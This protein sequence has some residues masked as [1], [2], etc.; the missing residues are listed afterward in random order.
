[1]FLEDR[2]KVT[3]T[4]NLDKLQKIANA[5]Q[6][7]GMIID[8]EP[9]KKVEA[10]ILQLKEQNAQLPVILTYVF[11]PALKDFESSLKKNISAIFY[12]PYDLN[13]VADK[14]HSLVESTSSY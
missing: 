11:N 3:T 9:N 1:M 6:F 4:S 10:I 14:L 8:S 12:K 2:F 13:E 5:C 7:D